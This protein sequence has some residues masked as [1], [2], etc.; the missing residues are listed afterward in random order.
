VT[1]VTYG[2][3]V[4]TATRWLRSGRGGLFLLA[5]VVGVGSGLGAVAF[6]YLVY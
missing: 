2:T 3:H 6:R 1:K 4:T 5:L